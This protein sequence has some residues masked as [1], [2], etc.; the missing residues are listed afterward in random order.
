MD[1]RKTLLD[2][3]NENVTEPDN[4][5][6]IDLPLSK[7]KPNPYQPR[8]EF[9]KAALNDLASS[10]KEHGVIQPIIVKD[11]IVHLYL[12]NVKQFPQL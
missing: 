1:E 4:E 7:V 6:I 8:K 5:Q 12:Q 3:I 9:D 10:I 2:L 11:V